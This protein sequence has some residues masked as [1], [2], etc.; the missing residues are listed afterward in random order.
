MTIGGCSILVILVSYLVL[1]WESLL[2]IYV[3]AC[4]MILII[5]GHVVHLHSRC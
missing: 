2:H 1:C 5:C 4:N 3:D